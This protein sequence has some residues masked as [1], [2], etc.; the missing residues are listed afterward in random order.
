M[1]TDFTNIT[2]FGNPVH[3]GSKTNPN[4]P[5]DVRCRIETIDEMN[6]IEYPFIGMLVYVLDEDKFYII[7]S[8]RD[9]YK[10]PGVEAS[11]IPGYRVDTYEEFKGNCNC[12]FNF[13]SVQKLLE[14]LYDINNGI[15]AKNKIDELANMLQN[16][17]GGNTGGD[18]G[19]SGDNDEGDE[20]EATGDYLTQPWHPDNYN[21]Y[22]IALKMTQESPDNIIGVSGSSTKKFSIEGSTYKIEDITINRNGQDEFYKIITLKSFPTKVKFSAGYNIE[23]VIN[24]CKFLARKMHKNYLL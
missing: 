3:I 15:D 23:K 24:M 10:I 21:E 19:D 17:G 2:G 8:I 4:Q 18:S 6:L 12:S 13:D 16:Q 22:Q 20:E 1:A 14:I 11:K 9:V 7:K 5:T